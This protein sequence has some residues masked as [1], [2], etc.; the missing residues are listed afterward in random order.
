M[1]QALNEKGPRVMPGLVVFRTRVSQANDQLY[2]SH[3]G[4]PS[5]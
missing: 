4:S 3:D 1:R 2:G 5:L